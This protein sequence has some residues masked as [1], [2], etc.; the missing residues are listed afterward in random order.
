MS[1]NWLDGASVFLYILTRETIMVLGSQHVVMYLGGKISC[2]S[3]DRRTYY[4][5]LFKW[6]APPGQ[7]RAHNYDM[8][9][10]GLPT[11]PPLA[12]VGAAP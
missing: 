10:A 1:M 2:K 5:N 7:R 9:I 3:L 6:G 4:F 12:V 8:I 11:G